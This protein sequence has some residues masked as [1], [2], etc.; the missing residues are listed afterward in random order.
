MT[1][2]DYDDFLKELEELEIERDELKRKTFDEP[3]MLEK[4]F[5][6]LVKN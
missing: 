4:I 1:I 5:L 6:P 3:I 2:K